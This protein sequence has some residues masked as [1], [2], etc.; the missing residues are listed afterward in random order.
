MLLQSLPGL[1]AELMAA[2]SNDVLLMT[3]M[4]SHM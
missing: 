3:S 1:E 2:N 4:V